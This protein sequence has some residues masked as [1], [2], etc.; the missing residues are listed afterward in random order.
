MLLIL[1]SNISGKYLFRKWTYHLGLAL[2]TAIDIFNLFI[3]WRGNERWVSERSNDT[4]VTSYVKVYCVTSSTPVPIQQSLLLSDTPQPYTLYNTGSVNVISCQFSWPCQ[5]TA[6]MKSSLILNAWPGI[7][8]QGIP[9]KTPSLQ[10]TKCPHG[11]RMAWSSLPLWHFSMW[12]IQRSR[13][14]TLV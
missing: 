13:C 6:D 5:V 3:C 9:E 4:W 1:D 7:M 12:R 11:R 2:R 8:F 14:K 10:H